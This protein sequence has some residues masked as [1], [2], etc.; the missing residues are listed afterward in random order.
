MLRRRPC[1][2]P[3]F[4][5]K[6]ATGHQLDAAGGA[7]SIFSALAAMH[8]RLHPTLNLENADRNLQDLDF[9][10]GSAREHRSRHVL[11]NGSGFGG[12]NAALIARFRAAQL[13]SIR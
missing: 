1:R 2:I 4:A 11:C 10:S 5:T 8:D 7:E 6:S 3:I 12:V 9:V 13:P